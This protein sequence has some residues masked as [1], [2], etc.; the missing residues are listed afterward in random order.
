M[1]RKGVWH[2]NMPNKVKQ[3]LQVLRSKAETKSCVDVEDV[4][5]LIKTLSWT[6][7]PII[8]EDALELVG[9]STKR[10]DRT[11]PKWIETPSRIELLNDM[12]SSL[13][14]R[15]MSST[16]EQTIDP[17][18][19]SSIKLV[20]YDAEED[21]TGENEAVDITVYFEDKSGDEVPNIGIKLFL[22]EDMIEPLV[23]YKGAFYFIKP[24]EPDVKETMLV[25]GTGTVKQTKFEVQ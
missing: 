5:N 21:L 3:I 20:E 13:D 8:I 19:I 17:D 18:D 14:C 24:S 22:D 7:L 9:V 1:T 4:D 23:N 11:L 6:N 12:V 10:T 25:R 2:F 15:T 16:V